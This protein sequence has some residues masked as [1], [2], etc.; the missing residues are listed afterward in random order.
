MS[1]KEPNSRIECELYKG[2]YLTVRAQLINPSG[3]CADYV[4]RRQGYYLGESFDTEDEALNAARA[5]GRHRI[6][7]DSAELP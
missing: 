3:F 5:A 1:E 7:T 2:S 6:D 4:V